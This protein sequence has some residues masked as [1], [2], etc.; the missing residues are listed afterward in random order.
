MGAS[1][2]ED[3]LSQFKT[4][5]E[6]VTEKSKLKDQEHYIPHVPTDYHSE[7][8]LSIAGGSFERDAASAVLDLEADEGEGGSTQKEKMK[9]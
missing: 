9:W 6:E 3:E 5:S 1:V 2:S 8:G 4:V 7:K